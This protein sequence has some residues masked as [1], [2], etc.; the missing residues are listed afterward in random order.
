M[1][2]LIGGFSHETNT[3][4]SVQTDLNAF[5]AHT[6]AVGEDA[7]HVARNTETGVGG[8]IDEIVWFVH[9]SVRFALSSTQTFLHL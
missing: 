1:K 9:D 2:W 5:R 7:A 3:F 6:Y 4:S 8:F